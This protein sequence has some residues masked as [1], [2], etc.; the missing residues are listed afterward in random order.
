[1]AEPLI[2]TVRRP[3]STSSLIIPH[4]GSEQRS[5][6]PSPS[7][8][9]RRALLKLYHERVDSVY[10]VLHWP[11]VVSLINANHGNPVE[12]ASSLSIRA[13]ESA[14]HFMSLC[15]ITDGESVN[16]DLGIR[17][18]M[19]QLHRSAVEGMLARSTLLHDPD[20]NILQAFLIYLIA[21]RTCF[22][23]AF[24][25]TL[26]AIAVRVATALGLGEESEQDFSALDLQVRRLLFFG[27]GILDTHAA[28]DRGT[29]PILPSKA[30]RTPPLCVDDH[31]IVPTTVPTTTS[32]AFTEMSHTAL[33]YDAM[34]CSRKLHEVSCR[35]Q[36]EQSRWAEMLEI[37]AIFERSVQA[38]MFRTRVSEDPLHRLT[39][40]SAQRILVSMRLILRRPP[41]RQP[42]L[43]D[44]IDEFD[45]LAA[46][47]EV[48]EQHLQPTP[49]DLQ[50]WAWKNWVQWHALAVV[51]AELS[52]RPTGPLSDRGFLVA[53]ESFRR[54]ALLVADSHTGMLWKPIAKLMR[55]VR[56]I[57]IGHGLDSVPQVTRDIPILPKDFIDNARQLN[58]SHCEDFDTGDFTM[59]NLENDIPSFVSYNTGQQQAEYY[60]Y[61][62]QLE[63][64]NVLD[65]PNFPSGSPPFVWDTFIQDVNFPSQ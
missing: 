40:M 8:N 41:H 11:T 2:E 19:I 33:I 5:L 63:V 52:V 32:F 21:L 7:P 9:T 37:V 13:L 48:L 20:L 1:M 4:F 46:A 57:R 51:L 65:N 24:T 3:R 58:S 61:D 56:Q 42:R 31:D 53:S 25:W 35:E 54:Y 36:S 26:V 34:I 29:V 60:P 16:M 38:L 27:I 55:R 6:C 22:N 23:G 39:R 30:F 17:A 12:S 64:D 14:I 49:S 18:D 59:W 43:V 45:V 10:K 62:P 44:P 28:L 50:P 47:T 15:T